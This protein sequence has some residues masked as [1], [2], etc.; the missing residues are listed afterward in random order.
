M[1]VTK[2]RKLLITDYTVKIDVRGEDGNTEKKDLP[3]KV[4]DSLCALLFHNDLKL[5]GK[6]LLENGK[7]A[8][9][10]E[11][12]DEDF[13]LLT[14]AEF[15]KIKFSIDTI[16]GYGRNEIQLVQRVEEAEEVEVEVKEVEEEKKDGKK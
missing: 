15:G 5:G 6:D 3:Y 12:C 16:R 4:R 7:V 13:I 8:D 10:L 14:E 9:K 1:S 2:M 11:V